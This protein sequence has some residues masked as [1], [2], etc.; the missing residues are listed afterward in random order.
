MRPGRQRRGK[1]TLLKLVADATVPRLREHPR[2]PGP[3]SSRSLENF[4]TVLIPDSR[5]RT[6]LAVIGFTD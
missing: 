2:R 6:V 3:A 4:Q 5:G 1:S